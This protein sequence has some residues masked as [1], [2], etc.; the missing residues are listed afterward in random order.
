MMKKNDVHAESMRVCTELRA[1]RSVVG[2][3]VA[4]DQI[5]W[6]MQYWLGRDRVVAT[7]NHTELTTEY[8]VVDR[9]NDRWLA[10]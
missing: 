5:R 6:D 2:L 7:E 10:R 4:S 9:V 8:S 3:R 1:G